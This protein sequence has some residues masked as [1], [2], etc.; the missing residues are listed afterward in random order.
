MFIQKNV[1]EFQVATHEGSKAIVDTKNIDN[2]TVSTL[3]LADATEVNSGT[4]SC[5]PS[6]AKEASIKV[7]VLTGKSNCF[8]LHF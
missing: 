5:D 1:D 4:Y 8:F 7:H 6:N 2:L 3:K